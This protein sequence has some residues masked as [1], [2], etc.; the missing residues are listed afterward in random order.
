MPFNLQRG[1]AHLPNLQIAKSGVGYSK[2]EWLS[3]EPAS[4]SYHLLLSH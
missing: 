2:V 4:V 3:P 1:Q